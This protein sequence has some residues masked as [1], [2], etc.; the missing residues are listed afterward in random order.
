[1]AATTAHP[2]AGTAAAAASRTVVTYHWDRSAVRSRAPEILRGMGLD[3]L[4]KSTQARAA[5]RAKGL[6]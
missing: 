5:R 2:R 4:E 6:A 1:M 3:G